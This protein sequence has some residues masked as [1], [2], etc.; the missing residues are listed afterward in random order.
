MR[1]KITASIIGTGSYLPEK[2]ITNKD[3]ES[4]V[5][6]SDEWITTRTGIK[7]RHIAA[8][9]EYTSDMG[10]KAAM[11]ALHS[12]GKKPSAIDLIIVATITPDMLFPS[13]ACFVQDKIG[14]RNAACFDIGAA[15]SGYIYAIEIAKRL[16]ETGSHNTILVIASEK[17]SAITDWSDRNTCVLFGDGA[18]AC[19]ISGEETGKPRILCTYTGADSSAAELLMMP[20][21]G[22][23]FPAS[24]QTVEKKMHFLKMEGREVF[25][26]AV[27][28]MYKAAERIMKKCDVKIDEINCFLPHQAN[29]RIIDAVAKKIGIAKEKIH[30]N[31]QKFGNMSAAT[32]AVGLDE[33]FRGWDLKPGDKM[34]VD[35]FGAGFTFGSLIIEW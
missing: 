7:E 22:T 3:L 12:A 26:N 9:D 29:I 30:L 25:K 15:C 23:R 20:G 10:A 35:A 27:L 11:R 17:L 5:D 4:M 33:V 19:I 28:S 16:V 32:V 34:L 13:T 18:G 1:N 24:I 2:V 31:I 21:G 14:A 8:D 6:T